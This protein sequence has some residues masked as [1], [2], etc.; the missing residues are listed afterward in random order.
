[1]K[2]LFNCFCLMVCLTLVF[3]LFTSCYKNPIT[4]RYFPTE[5]AGTEWATRDDTIHFYIDKA[6]TGPFYGYLKTETGKIDVRIDMGSVTSLIFVYSRDDEQRTNLL[7]FWNF[8]KI[9][10]KSVTISVEQSTYFN[11]GDTFVIYRK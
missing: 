7:E 11:V 1:M 10:K 6:N 5:Q 8:E 3:V 2:K 9:N 4:T